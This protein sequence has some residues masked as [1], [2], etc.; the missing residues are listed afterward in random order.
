MELFIPR[1]D[2]IYKHRYDFIL[3]DIAKGVLPEIPVYRQLI[4]EDLFFILYFVMEIPGCNRPFIVNVCKEIEQGPD[5]WT[6]DLWAR[7]HYKSSILTKGRTIQRILKYPEK[8]T[9]IVSHTRPMAKKFLRPL[10][11]LL[12]NSDLLKKCFPDILYG[13]PRVESPK[14]S[15]DDGI[16]VKRKSLA[17]SESTLEAHGVIDSMPIGV[18]FDWIIMDDLETED[19][20]RNP[21]VVK[22]SR[23]KVDLVYDLTTED[24]SVS[25]IGTPYSHEGIYI[26]FLRDKISDEETKSP[27]FKYRRKPATEDGTPMGKPVLLTQKALN[28]ERVKK[29][30]YVFMCQQMIDPTPTGARKFDSVMLRSIKEKDLPAQRY[31]FMVID[32]A[33]DKD[34]TGT[35]AWSIGVISVQ[36]EADDIGASKIFIERLILSPLKEAEAPR[37]I[38]NLYIKNYP[39]L[40]IGVEKTGQS[41]TEIHVANELQKNGIMISVDNGTLVI[42]RP[43]GR[44][45][46]KRIERNLSLPFYNGKIYIVEES[47]SNIYTERLRAEMDKFPYWHDDGLDMLAYFYDLIKDY[48]FGWFNEED[49]D[50]IEYQLQGRNAVTGY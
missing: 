31:K 14:W 40:Q 15:E 34:G 17:R 36:P 16:I 26:P 2:V 33:G 28:S 44:N 22:A 50:E 30:E 10:M 42:L 12:E 41:T 27:L 29:G 25:V 37:L 32:P 39:I 43:A 45:K 18:H 46:V 20:V 23:Q 21:E 19:L 4:L 7:K 1:H 8:C 3:R 48:H 24:G 9:M 49:E 5:G 6:M 47:I 38:A 13:N 11:S 35:D